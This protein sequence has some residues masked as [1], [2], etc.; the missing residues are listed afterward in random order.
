MGFLLEFFNHMTVTREHL[1]GRKSALHVV[2]DYY[3]FVQLLIGCC[4]HELLDT[5]SCTKILHSCGECNLKWTLLLES[6]A[7][8]F[9]KI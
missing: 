3:T 4:E 9:L 7:A 1:T 6:V 2:Q 5:V 8:L